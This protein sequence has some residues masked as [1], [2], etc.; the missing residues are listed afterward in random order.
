MTNHS[1]IYSLVVS[2]VNTF[3]INFPIKRVW[4]HKPP[5]QYSQV[6]SSFSL[7]VEMKNLF[8]VIMYHVRRLEFYAAY[9]ER[10]CSPSSIKS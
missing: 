4:L 1:Y 10:G 6:V 7:A 5:S 3:F 9:I 2:S 8:G